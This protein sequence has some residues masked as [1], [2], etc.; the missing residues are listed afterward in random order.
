MQLADLF[1]TQCTKRNKI[2]EVL[3][4]PDSW[5]LTAQTNVFILFTALQTSLPAEIR[6]ELA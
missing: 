6:L 3:I 1:L 4:N 2:K 5:P